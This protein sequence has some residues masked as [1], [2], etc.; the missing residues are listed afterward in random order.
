MQVQN[1]TV[2]CSLFLSQGTKALELHFE[3]PALSNRN[4]EY[5]NEWPMFP[6]GSAF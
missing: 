1:R 6:G 2:S 5:E 3:T 4:G